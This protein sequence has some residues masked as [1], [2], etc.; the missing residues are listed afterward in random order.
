MAPEVIR[1]GL[2][3]S[4][5]FFCTFFI[6]PLSIFF[7]CRSLS[8]SLTHTHTHNKY[9]GGC[10][11]IIQGYHGCDS[12]RC[13]SLV[14]VTSTAYTLITLQ[15]LSALTHIFFSNP[16]SPDSLSNISPLPQVPLTWPVVTSTVSELSCGRWSR[17]TS[18]TWRGLRERAWLLS[19]SCT[20]W[21]LVHT[22][23][24]H[25]H[26]HWETVALKSVANSMSRNMILYF[27]VA[28]TITLYHH[29]THT[30]ICAIYISLTKILLYIENMGKQCTSREFWGKDL[31]RLPGPPAIQM[32]L[33]R[34]LE[35]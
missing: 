4:P 27:H 15:K 29:H 8:L 32:T 19:L 9:G 16:S 26:M 35:D 17:G 1:G 21:P 13:A 20:E 5:L 28:M 3:F 23:N 11:Y 2:I 12:V 25:T 7:S 30:T 6:S 33:I 10:G 31:H 14:V 34:T 22:A 18:R 24:L